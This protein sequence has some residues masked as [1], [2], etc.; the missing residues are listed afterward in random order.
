MSG[1]DNGIGNGDVTG[2]TNSGPGPA[3]RMSDAGAEQVTLQS[4]LDRLTSLETTISKL[5]DHVN[6]L[7]DASA[8]SNA[9]TLVDE[10]GNTM[11]FEAAHKSAL[12]YMVDFLHLNHGKANPVNTGQA[13]NN[14]PVA[15][16]PAPASGN[17]V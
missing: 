8:A 17:A 12:D 7:P 6:N 5:E 1:T 4:I 13:Q 11:Q 14:P 9:T 15:A 2:A 3:E 16:L 10:H